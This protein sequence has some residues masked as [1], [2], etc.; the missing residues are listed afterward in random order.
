MRKLFKRKDTLECIATREE[1][2]N[3]VKENLLKNSPKFPNEYWPVFN[4]HMESLSKIKFCDCCCQYNGYDNSITFNFYL[5][6]NFLLVVSCFLDDEPNEPAVFLIYKDNELLV[7]DEM[8][9][10]D[11]VQTLG[12]VCNKFVEQN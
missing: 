1:R 7:A 2:F 3:I 12:E 4:G 11:I 9:V 8:C 5:E 6:L 10:A